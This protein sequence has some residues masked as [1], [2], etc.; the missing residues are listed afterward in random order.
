MKADLKTSM[1]DQI[2]KEKFQYL[3]LNFLS[4]L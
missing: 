3:V 1:S 4:T 2:I